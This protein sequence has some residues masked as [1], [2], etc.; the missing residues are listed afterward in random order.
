M[1]RSIRYFL[2][3]SILLSITIASAINGVGNYLLDEKVIQPY[4]DGQLV[5][6]SSIIDILNHSSGSSTQ[7]RSEIIDYI[8]KAQPMS[9]QKFIFQ[10]W[11]QR[12]AL[13]MHSSYD[14]KFAL[15]NMPLGFSDQEF[16]NQNWRVYT[17]Y[18]TNEQV[19]IVVGE[20]Y[21]LRREL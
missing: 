9:G 17:T 16:N 21:T 15:K 13:L 3:I 6:I 5:R 7:T 11:D 14:F 4:L 1:I 8:V 12:G 18:D 20:L 19:K 2:L 10:V